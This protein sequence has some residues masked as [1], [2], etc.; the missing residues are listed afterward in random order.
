MKDDLSVSEMSYFREKNHLEDVSSRGGPSRCSGRR[1]SLNK[2]HQIVPM[3][4]PSN[5]KDYCISGLVT[6]T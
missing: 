4:I 5:G 1:R 3:T 6:D 2:V